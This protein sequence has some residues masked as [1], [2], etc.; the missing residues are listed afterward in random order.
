MFSHFHVTGT[1]AIFYLS[2]AFARYSDIFEISQY[3][4]VA[5][6]ADFGGV[7]KLNRVSIESIVSRSSARRAYV[8][9]NLHYVPNSASPPHC[10]SNR[11]MKYSQTAIVYEPKNRKYGMRINTRPTLWAN[12]NDECC[13]IAGWL[14]L[15]TTECCFFVA[16]HV[17]DTNSRNVFQHGIRMLRYGVCAE[18]ISLH[19][20]WFDG[21]YFGTEHTEERSV[22]SVCPIANSNR[23]ALYCACHTLRQ[24]AYLFT[25]NCSSK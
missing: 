18:A 14:Q 2:F 24:C 8:P 1:W 6:E 25:R 16:A 3:V 7:C 23:K 22:L 21:V 19:C 20:E 13:Y 12:E 4:F 9:S 17:Y 11:K 15:G 5:N 10:A